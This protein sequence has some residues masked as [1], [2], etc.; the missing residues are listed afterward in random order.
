[1]K[2]ITINII[3]EEDYEPDYPVPPE[4]LEWE[5]LEAFEYLVQTS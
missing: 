5:W 1:M 4:D 2:N 3:I